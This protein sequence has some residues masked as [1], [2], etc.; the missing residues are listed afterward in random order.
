VTT[1]AGIGLGSTVEELDDAYGRRLT[2]ESSSPFGVT[3]SVSTGG[4][5]L[6]SGT[7]TESVP[8]GQVTSV[9]GGFGCGS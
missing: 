8:S 9:A 4:P 6:L 2:I 7:L 1:S 3:F 5:G